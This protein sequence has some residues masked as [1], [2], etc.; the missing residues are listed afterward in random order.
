MKWQHFM[1]HDHGILPDTNTTLTTTRCTS[2]SSKDKFNAHE[3]QA[4]VDWL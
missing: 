1:G 3:C 4:D 2:K